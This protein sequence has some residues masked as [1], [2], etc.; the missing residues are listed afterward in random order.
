M[1]HVTIVTENAR[2]FL[3]FSRLREL[4]SIVRITSLYVNVLV[5]IASLNLISEH[6]VSPSIC[7]IPKQDLTLGN[8]PQYS[9]PVYDQVTFGGLK[10]S[11]VQF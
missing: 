1:E 6:R 5:I 3:S 8:Y 7:Q 10:V 2:G 4:S 11:S 9:P